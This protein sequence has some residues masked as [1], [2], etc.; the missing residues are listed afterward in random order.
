MKLIGTIIFLFL[1]YTVS[2][3]AYYFGFAE[4]SYNKTDE[5]YEST[6]ILSTHDVEDFFRE[7]GLDIKEI[8]DHIGDEAM[9]AKMSQVLLKGFD[10][11]SG[12]IALKFESIGFEVLANGLTHFYFH[13]QKTKFEPKLSVRFDLMMDFLKEQQNKLTYL[14][15]E[16]SATI[17]FTQTMKAQTISID[18]SKP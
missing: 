2:A 8:E 7:K 18:I 11:K 4:I 3:H 12:N 1:S 9:L 10:V 6:L 14:Y 15:E 13:S 17:P 16:K 5:Q